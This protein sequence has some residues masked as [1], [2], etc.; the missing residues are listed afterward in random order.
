M[1]DGTAR[2]TLLYKSDPIR[3]AVWNRVFREE[4][5]DIALQVWSPDAPPSDA[6]Y[7]V[8]WIPPEDLE[9]SVPR[10]EVLFGLGAGVDHL[11]LDRLPPRVQLVRM[12]DPDLT[13]SMIE[14]VLYAVL[15]LHRDIP[16]YFADQREGRWSPRPVRRAADRTVGVMGLGVLGRAAAEALRDLGFAVRGWSASEKEIPGVACFAGPAALQDFLRSCEVLVCLL[17]LTDATRGILNAAAFSALPAGAG[18]VNVGRGGH[19][20]EA[21]LLAALESGQV[22][23]AM[24]DVLAT[25]P[26][27]PDHPLLCHP[28]VMLTPHVASATHPES[29]AR[30]VIRAIRRHRDGLPLENVVDRRQAY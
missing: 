13:R 21:D 9:R 3:G 30:Q 14:Y 12:V 15:A 18:L 5:P 17:P 2:P 23:A 8:A 1:G 22:S 7:L 24:L 11:D 26:P 19:V 20:V 27:A 25:E 6:A 4:A 10:L 28:K 29:A 16:A